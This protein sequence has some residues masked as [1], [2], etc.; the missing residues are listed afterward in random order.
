MIFAQTVTGQNGQS[1]IN[2]TWVFK[3]DFSNVPCLDMEEI[4]FVAKTGSMLGHR[5]GA[6]LKTDPVFFL[7]SFSYIPILY[8]CMYVCIRV[9]L[10]HN[11]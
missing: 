9:P 5:K 10:P 11:H 2:A 6:E 7:P 8:E 3:P 4:F 1:G